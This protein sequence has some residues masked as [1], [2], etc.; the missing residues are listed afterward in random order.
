M[1]RSAHPHA[2]HAEPRSFA[3]DPDDTR[4]EDLHAHIRDGLAIMEALCGE[5]TARLQ[6]WAPLALDWWRDRAAE[7]GVR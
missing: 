6:A 3:S 4:L 7:L 2:D 1:A 5:R